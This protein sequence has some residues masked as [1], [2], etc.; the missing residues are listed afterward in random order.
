MESG[1]TVPMASCWRKL[2]TLTPLWAACAG[3]QQSDQET[4]LS[5]MKRVVECENKLS[6]QRSSTITFAH[7][8]EHQGDDEILVHSNGKKWMAALTLLFGLVAFR[9][10]EL[11]KIT[12][13]E[14]V[15]KLMEDAEELITKAA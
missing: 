2:L 1:P 10:I 15:A 7:T 4:S 12:G 14:P 3:S 13:D 5:L 8:A 11:R 9:Q 6:Q